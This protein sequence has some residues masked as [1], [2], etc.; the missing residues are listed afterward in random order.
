M[1]PCWY[2]RSGMPDSYPRSVGTR[3]LVTRVERA[4]RT[5]GLRLLLELSATVGLGIP[6]ILLAFL[7]RG[8][9]SPLISLDQSV[10]DGMHGVAVAHPWLVDVLQDVSLVIG[11]WVLRPV[12]TL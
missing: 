12:V 4:D 5:L 1:T 8:N 3:N 9:W 11:P 6:V 10:A 7:V 2:H